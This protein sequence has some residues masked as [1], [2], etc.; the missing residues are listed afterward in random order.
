M[1]GMTDAG[2]ARIE[3]AIADGLTR[4]QAIEMSEKIATFLLDRPKKH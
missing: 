3:K 1:P 4:D 2:R